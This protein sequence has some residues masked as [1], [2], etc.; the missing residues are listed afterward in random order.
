MYKLIYLPDPTNEC[1]NYYQKFISIE[2]AVHFR[3]FW[4][5]NKAYLYDVIEVQDV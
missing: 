4:E 5:G 2:E 1:Y 3:R